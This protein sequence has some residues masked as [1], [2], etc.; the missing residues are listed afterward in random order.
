MSR[1]CGANFCVFS[2][3]FSGGCPQVSKKA[4]LTRFPRRRA[5]K[6]LPPDLFPI[7]TGWRFMKNVELHLVSSPLRGSLLQRGAPTRRASET[8]G[9]NIPLKA[10][11]KKKRKNFKELFINS[12]GRSGCSQTL[13]DLSKA[14]IKKS[15]R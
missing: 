15:E 10:E 7:L 8:V 3:F 1:L 11:Q 5:R 14:A 12:N 9:S 4:D 13:S 2:F 6:A